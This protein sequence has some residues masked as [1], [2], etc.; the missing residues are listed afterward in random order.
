MSDGPFC[1]FDPVAGFIMAMVKRSIIDNKGGT[2]FRFACNNGY[3]IGV[4]TP[5]CN[6]WAGWI[7]AVD[8]MI[9]FFPNVI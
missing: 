2:R 9:N 6:L 5:F 8:K 7:I 3:S 4:K 1:F